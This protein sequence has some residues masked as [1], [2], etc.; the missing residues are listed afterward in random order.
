MEDAIIEEEHQS[1]VVTIVSFSQRVRLIPVV[2]VMVMIR[3][4]ASIIA[5]TL[6]MF[7]DLH[8]NAC[9]RVNC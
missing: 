9:C 4:D 5:E 2:A 1:E 3:E 7:G 8:S 6:A